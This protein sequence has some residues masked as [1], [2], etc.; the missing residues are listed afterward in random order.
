MTAPLQPRDNNTQRETL[1]NQ[2]LRHSSY[3]LNASSVTPSPSRFPTAPNLATSSRSNDGYL[4]QTPLPLPVA[5][6]RQISKSSSSSF[7]LAKTATQESLNSTVASSPPRPNP[8]DSDLPPILLAIPRARGDTGYVDVA[9]LPEAHPIRKAI[10]HEV[11]FLDRHANQSRARWLEV[12]KGTAQCI[13]IRLSGGGCI[14]AAEGKKAACRQCSSQQRPCLRMKPGRKDGVW[15]ITVLPLTQQLRH[16]ACYDDIGFWILQDK[17]KS[18][19]R[20][21]SLWPKA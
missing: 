4:T 16:S 2:Q 19:V 14:L 18:E 5:P 13:T 20:Q 8:V 10:Y 11:A 12:G 9:T 6:S 17:D 21:P 1:L 3:N 15:F 7:S